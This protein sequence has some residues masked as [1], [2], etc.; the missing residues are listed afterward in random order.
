MLSV[1][2]RQEALDVVKERF[3]HLI[4]QTEYVALE[5]SVG[6]VLAEDISSDENIPTFDRSTVDGYAVMAE[7]TFGSG[8]SMPAQLTVA[9]EILMG[10]D[11]CLKLCEGQCIKISTGGMLPEGADAVV[12]VENTDTGFDGLCLCFKA[13]SKYENVTRLGDDVKKGS[14]VA[15]KGTLISSRHIGVLSGIG[16]TLVPVM[17]R[18]VVG[19]ISTGDEV[20]PIEEKLSPGK[21][22]DINS[23]ILASLVRQ[24]GCEIK[25]YGIIPDNRQ[26]I[27]DTVKKAADCCDIVLISGGSSAGSKDMTVQIIDALG[28]TY[29]HGLAMKPGKPTIL[30]KVNGKAVFGL[31]GHPVAA[32]F[33]AVSLVK[34]LCENM[35]SVLIPQGRVKTVIQSN[36]S[37]NHGRE[38]MVCVKLCAEGAVPVYGKSGVVSQLSASDGYIIIERN[39]EGLKKGDEVEVILF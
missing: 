22:R 20:V 1:I 27:T 21:V 10:E 24:W 32:Y 35:L 17:K 8:E 18:P 4:A 2:S 13:V 28:E 34:P 23:H 9:G 19:V 14:T 11:T 29:F 39:L 33:V 6:R 16:C 30:G 5:E 37:S 26:T 15:C 12:M 36:I 3:S 25:Q 31:P 7:D 38:E